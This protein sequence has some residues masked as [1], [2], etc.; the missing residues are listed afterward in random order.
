M[1]PLTAD[2]RAEPAGAEEREYV[3][4]R[5]GLPDRYLLSPAGRHL[6]KN[7]PVLHAALRILRREGRPI[8]VVASGLATDVTYHGPDLI[9]LGY[10]S[11]R[12]LQALL[13]QSAGIVQ[14]SLYEAGS[15]P[16]LEAMAAGRPVAISRIPSVLEQIER[17]GLVA[18]LST[19]S[20]P[21][22]SPRRYTPV[23]GLARDR[24]GR[25]RCQRDSGR[26]A[27]LG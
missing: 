14:T 21:R 3:R 25:A 22:T 27:L 26:R 13:E 16:M 11:A 4:R 12:E 1:I 5:F 18:E 10:I 9:G 20:I 19:R 15:F 2:S 24:G 23:G 7:Y 8:T 6:H 17:L